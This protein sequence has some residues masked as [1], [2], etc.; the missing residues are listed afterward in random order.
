MLNKQEIFNKL[1]LFHI[2][3]N[4]KYM[5]HLLIVSEIFSFLV[6][7]SIFII[8]STYEDSFL[9]SIFKYLSI[10]SIIFYQIFS[11]EVYSLC[12]SLCLLG[13]GLK[14]ISLLVFLLYD[15][16]KIEKLIKQNLKSS[17]FIKII[18][19]FLIFNNYFLIHIEN[20]FLLSS[21]FDCNQNGTSLKNQAF[22]IDNCSS[23][24]QIILLSTSIFI[25]FIN[26]LI[27]FTISKAQFVILINDHFPQTAF[28]NENSDKINL[29][30]YVICIFPFLYYK[31]TTK[32][33]QII[34]LLIAFLICLM[35]FAYNLY[36]I[37]RLY[38]NIYNSELLFKLRHS[39]LFLYVYFTFFALLNI[40]VFR[41]Y[42]SN[43]T[44]IIIY[45]YYKS[46][47][48]V[49]FLSGIIISLFYSYYIYEK[50]IKSEHIHILADIQEK[51][52][53]LEIKIINEMNIFIYHLNNINNIYSLYYILNQY[54]N[55][56]RNC[57]IKE[58]CYCRENNEII[59]DGVKIKDEI[60]GN[61][62]F[63]DDI[64]ELLIN[65]NLSDMRQEE[66][67]RCYS[68]IKIILKYKISYYSYIRPYIK[69]NILNFLFNLVNII[70]LFNQNYFHSSFIIESI[71]SISH[72]SLKYQLGLYILEKKMK[73]NTNQYH[74]KCLYNKNFPI[75]NV[76][77]TSIRISLLE[78]LIYKNLILF[79]D[80]LTN[81]Y[82][83]PKLNLNSILIQMR[84]FELNS[85]K[86]NAEYKEMINSDDRMLL[87]SISFNY[88]FYIY[89][90][91]L[92]KVDSKYI[93]EK[94]GYLMDLIQNEFHMKFPNNKL[95]LEIDNHVDFII[96]II[97]YELCRLLGYESNELENKNIDSIIP[98]YLKTKHVE[99]QKNIISNNL[100]K[101]IYMQKFCLNKSGFLCTF[102]M[103]GCFLQYREKFYFFS[104]III[105]HDD[106]NINKIL[107]SDQVTNN[108]LTNR[109]NNTD[110]ANENESSTKCY[111]I[112]SDNGRLLSF[113]ESYQKE[114]CMF[115][116]VLEY[117][118]LIYNINEIFSIDPIQLYKKF[119]MR[120]VNEKTE[121]IV[122]PQKEKINVFNKSEI[123]NAKSRKR[124]SILSSE[125]TGLISGFSKIT[126]TK[127]GN[128]KYNFELISKIETE[129][130][131]SVNIVEEMYE[132]YIQFEIMSSSYK[133]ILSKN[134][135]FY[136]LAMDYNSDIKPKLKEFLMLDKDFKG[137]LSILKEINLSNESVSI[138]NKYIVNKVEM[139]LR[140]VF[141]IE[142]ILSSV[143]IPQ[144]LNSVYINLGNQ[145]NILS[146]N[147]LNIS[148]KHFYNEDIY[149]NS[150]FKKE[151]NLLKIKPFIFLF[152]ILNL[153]IAV[154]VILFEK[155]YINNYINSERTL[156]GYCSLQILNSFQFN[157]D[158]LKISS[159]LI[160]DKS[161]SS[162]KLSNNTF[163]LRNILDTLV[164]VHN[165]KMTYIEKSLLD[166]N[167]KIIEVSENNLFSDYPNDYK[168]DVNIYYKTRINNITNSKEVSEN[169]SKVFWSYYTQ[170]S[171]IRK[172]QV[173]LLKE[174]FFD[175]LDFHNDLNR[176]YDFNSI[177]YWLE[178]FYRPLNSIM[179][180]KMKLLREYTNIAYN[181]YII[182]SYIVGGVL[183]VLIILE[184]LIV[185]FSSRKLNSINNN[186]ISALNIKNSSFSLLLEAYIIAISKIENLS[187]FIINPIFNSEWI[188]EEI[189]KTNVRKGSI[190]KE[191]TLK[192]MNTRKK[193]GV[194]NQKSG[195]STPRRSENNVASSNRK[196]IYNKKNT[197]RSPVNNQNEE[198]SIINEDKQRAK[199]IKK[200]TFVINFAIGMITT[201]QDLVDKISSP[202]SK[203][204]ESKF[205]NEYMTISEDD[206]AQQILSNP[207]IL[208]KE[209]YN[210]L[211]FQLNE[212]LLYGFI[213]LLKISII[214]FIS[215]EMILI[216]SNNKHIYYEY[217][218]F[219]S[220]LSSPLILSTFYFIN[221][222]FP[223]NQ[224]SQLSFAKFDSKDKQFYHQTHYHLY[225][226]LNTSLLN[227]LND[228]DYLELSIS[229]YVDILQDDET[230]RISKGMFSENIKKANEI[231]IC[232]AYDLLKNLNSSVFGSNETYSSSSNDYMIYNYE[233]YGDM[234][235]KILDIFEYC[236]ENST[237]K[238]FHYQIA[239]NNFKKDIINIYNNRQ[240]FNKTINKNEIYSIT[241]EEIKIFVLNMVQTLTYGFVFNLY[242]EM[243]NS[244]L[245]SKTIL[246]SSLLLCLYFLL[247]C[248]MFVILNRKIN[249]NAEF[250]KGLFYFYS[251]FKNGEIFIKENQVDDKKE[252]V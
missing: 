220:T 9:F 42:S 14:I 160:I 138:Y 116:E 219:S 232:E 240:S 19:F 66:Y 98:S 62:D 128:I 82:Y 57:N 158:L 171:H 126:K 225:D 72:L 132:K 48:I 81:L 183:L 137:H 101:E 243:D 127:K 90:Q 252:G 164:D 231:N 131:V 221:T 69:K 45:S 40:I 64:K 33:Q 133:E 35:F 67:I 237:N 60:I 23:S 103:I 236:N 245:K 152:I 173:S 16:G 202:E 238:K 224:I 25:I 41:D 140:K 205:K 65:K 170:A 250:E 209:T 145:T 97:P 156:I 195:P 176:N 100:Y 197:I 208:T 4:Q 214:F 15:S 121:K 11:K 129:K 114:F 248:W 86:I 105:N 92:N 165:N 74:I 230:Q 36:S 180:L 68:T 228:K 178:S 241:N 111:C 233:V 163:E 38:I 47:H 168:N 144:N 13:F 59:V 222:F 115:Y 190:K 149:S 135:Q 124:N 192:S 24:Q 223:Q 169:I 122:S 73:F 1:Y 188:S 18:L 3:L 155:V 191:M 213:I 186:F 104:D 107:I 93:S 34:I 12:Y 5:K 119:K 182:L 37:K 179:Y 7:F 71:K 193:S 10:N 30:Y 88:K 185:F 54:E 218:L 61:Y 207:L 120:G 112:I 6:I 157:F 136:N 117:E 148:E 161:S 251:C 27:G 17:I 32:I 198:E 91:L 201:N 84:K 244:S 96:K 49:V 199:S 20:M 55:H 200:K 203:I 53:L 249:Q 39:L 134:N 43:S 130:Q 142:I 44:L 147:E 235:K 52:I 216:I 75:Y 2:F 99:L 215:Y 189:K 110:R 210:K 78:D 239:M 118:D 229:S 123:T 77:R 177:S 204:K 181:K 153:I 187:D 150:F 22:F 212:S 28:L 154:I 246:A 79:R 184:I 166:L 63:Y 83:N 247:L 102:N 143:Q 106:N 113:S 172:I 95:L 51:S 175:S 206:K 94:L 56:I 76:F 89:S 87:K 211:G 167:R 234:I 58:T 159:L 141:I 227:P 217:E 108:P 46:F 50:Y 125:K 226:F 139:N 242:F 70:Y 162:N 31:D 29:F 196:M 194:T 8:L 151:S 146:S 80:L 26:F 109:K 21:A 174:Y 85:S